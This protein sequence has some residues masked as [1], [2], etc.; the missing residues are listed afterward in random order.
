MF[1]FIQFAGADQDEL[2]RIKE[3]IKAKGA[4]WTAGET[5]VSK[6][7]KA[8]RDKLSGTILS[9]EGPQGSGTSEIL[10]GLPE[11]FDWLSSG[12]VTP[13]KNQGSCGSCW[14]FAC[15]AQVE[16][17]EMTLKPPAVMAAPAGKP[18]EPPGK[19]PKPPAPP[20]DYTDLSEQ[21]LVSC[22][23]DNNGCRGG[24]LDNAS[25]FLENIGTVDEECFPYSAR[26]LPCRRACK[27][28]ASRIAKIN[29]WAWVAENRY[30]PTIVELKNAIYF[31][32]PVTAAFR[33]YDDFHYYKSG[34]YQ[35]LYDRDGISTVGHAILIVGWN[36]NLSEG[37]G[38][39]KVKNS[40][41]T[42]WGEDGYFNIAY[43]EMEPH[44]ID[45][46]DPEDP[47]PGGGEADVNFGRD[48]V[49]YT[50][51]GYPAPPRIAEDVITLW[52]SI[53]AEY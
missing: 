9:D 4:K 42:G 47:I 27:D 36:D 1:I 10:E 25:N 12:L 23:T 43:T 2:K 16:F 34:I 41:G 50:K 5:S 46:G 30:L 39:W 8:E 22:N 24:W 38:Y 28:S 19:P 51:T 33:V 7:S 31:N 37:I 52:G 18:P 3:A 20:P 26:D 15:V 11:A 49:K 14:A 32:G 13:V 44:L 53:K 45:T 6:L 40:W 35:C 17:F 48:A 21:Y 29:D